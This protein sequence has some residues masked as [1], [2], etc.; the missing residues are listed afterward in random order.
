MTGT[1]DNS[2]LTVPIPVSA[3]DAVAVGCSV[4]GDQNGLTTSASVVAGVATWT[5]VSALPVGT[6]GQLTMVCPTAN[7]VTPNGNTYTPTGTFTSTNAG[8]VSDV[9][10]VVT[11]SASSGVQVNKTRDGNPIEPFTDTLVNY[12]ITS[13]N[14]LW[15]NFGTGGPLHAG[16]TYLQDVVV[17]DVLPATAQYVSSTGG[18]VLS[19]AVGGFGG[20]V[21]WPAYS[22]TAV[23]YNTCK[24]FGITLT[25]PSPPNVGDGDPTTPADNVTNTANVTAQPWLRPNDPPVTS[26]VSLMHGFQPVGSGGAGFEMSKQIR[27]AGHVYAAY[28]R[29]DSTGYAIAF[30]NTGNSVV[31]FSF[32]D[33]LPCGFTSDWSGNGIC[34]AT[35]LGDWFTTFFTGVSAVS[36]PATFSGH[37]TLGNVFSVTRPANGVWPALTPFAAG[38]YISD[39]T[40]SGSLN[41]LQNGYLF[42]ESG[43]IN[44]ALP[45]VA[46]AGTPYRD[47]YSVAPTT[48]APNVAVEN[49]IDV[50]GGDLTATDAATGAAIPQTF[51][52][53]AHCAINVILPSVPRWG[54]SKSAANAVQAPGGIVD[55]AMWSRLTTAIGPTNPVIADLL[56]VG[57]GYVPGSFTVTSASGSAGFLNPTIEV[58]DDYNGT[59]RTLVRATLFVTP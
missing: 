11:V 10:D 52:S 27:N 24:V 57:M 17:T 1:C 8:T 7:G 59:G 2:V 15:S 50:D 32:T 39:F 14:S 58:I 49:C 5:F 29:G 4:T 56:P 53:A 6:S 18:G 40:F 47:P 12:S 42:L 35:D 41:S 46:P 13:C 48:V 9:G 21:T 19:G 31:D 43:T 34:S 20:T 25:Y 3:P 38:E 44:P 26:T 33:Y 45:A 16:V 22:Q 51:S 54:I 30:N 37:T 36:Y 55:F 28:Q 23:D